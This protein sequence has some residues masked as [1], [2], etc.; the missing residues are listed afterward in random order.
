[1]ISEIFKPLTN[2]TRF[3]VRDPRGAETGSKAEVRNTRLSFQSSA[4]L[5]EGTAHRQSRSDSILISI[6]KKNDGRYRQ[7]NDIKLRSGTTMFA[8]SARKIRKIR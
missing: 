6:E 2:F 3:R 7:I 8:H 5:D 1:M 4:R